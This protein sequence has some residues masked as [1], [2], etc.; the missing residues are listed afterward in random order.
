MDSLVQHIIDARALPVQQRA[1]GERA[2]DMEQQRPAP[3][4]RSNGMEAVSKAA[5][6]SRAFARRCGA[7]FFLVLLWRM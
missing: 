4:A 1:W 3:S 7:A 5:A 6:S 2:A